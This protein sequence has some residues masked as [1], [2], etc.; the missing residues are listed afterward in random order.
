MKNKNVNCFIV[1]SLG[2]FLIYQ[3][4]LGQSK[5]TNQNEINSVEQIQKS[6]DQTNLL[7]TGSKEEKKQ[8]LKRLELLQSQILY[9]K[10]LQEKFTAK[11][12]KTELEI[13]ELKLKNSEGLETQK[14]L[15]KK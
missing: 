6:I 2:S 10:E 11:L 13:R 12:Q 8:L 4:I 3:G 14:M 9:R 7:L 5:N 15:E 1:I